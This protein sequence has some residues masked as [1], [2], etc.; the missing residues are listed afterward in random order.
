MQKLV[1]EDEPFRGHYFTEEGRIYGSSLL[2]VLFCL[3]LVD[4]SLEKK[5]GYVIMASDIDQSEADD[6]L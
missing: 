5:N 3:R 1:Q 6:I 4:N 2:K